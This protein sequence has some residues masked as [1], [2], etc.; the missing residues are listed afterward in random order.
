MDTVANSQPLRILLI[1]D[2]GLLRERLEE[3]LRDI[4]NV[5]LAGSADNESD[6][7]SVL[8]A[9]QWDFAL[10]DL[11]LKKGT[12]LGVLKAIGG[13]LRKA[14]G[15]IAVFTNFPFPQ[16]RERALALGADY[17]FD[18]ARE[19]KHLLELIAALAMTPSSQRMAMAS[20]TVSGHSGGNLH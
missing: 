6:A 4:D 17:F 11:Q 3:Q 2:S 20:S 7:I 16:Y 18:K 15:Q 12:G 9:V 1:E 10:V 13:R 19:F 8:N 5:V 14:R